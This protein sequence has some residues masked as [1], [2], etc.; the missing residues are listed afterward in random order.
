MLSGLDFKIISGGLL[1]KEL[2]YIQ[3]SHAEI[4]GLKKPQVFRCFNSGLYE[5][6]DIKTVFGQDSDNLVV[7]NFT[8]F[9]YVG[10]SVFGNQEWYIK[11]FDNDWVVCTNPK[12]IEIIN[13]AYNNYLDSNRYCN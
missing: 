13:K 1:T 5:D 12:H 9:P 6:T 8:Y 11:S 3:Y 7:G 10:F 2:M 4:P